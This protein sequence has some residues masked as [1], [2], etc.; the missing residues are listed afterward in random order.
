MNPVENNR[1]IPKINDDGFISGVI[2]L[3]NSS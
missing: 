2:A 1:L 3:I